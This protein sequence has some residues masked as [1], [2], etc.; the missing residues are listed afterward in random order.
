MLKKKKK[1]K[2]NSNVTFFNNVNRLRK[3]PSLKAKL[4]ISFILI[5]VIPSMIIASF[6]FSVSRNAMKDKVAEMT[7]E[8]SALIASSVDQSINET[9]KIALLPFSNQQL[10]NDFNNFDLN[11]FEILQKKRTAADYFLSIM[12][13]HP[14]VNHY[15]LVR[16]DGHVFGDPIQTVDTEEF[17][18][19]DFYQTVLE[20]N[21]EILWIG[22][23]EEDYENIYVFKSIKNDY[24]MDTGVLILTID[25]SYFDAV[26]DIPG[27]D[28]SIYLINEDNVTI[29]SNKEEHFGKPLTVHQNT[30]NNLVSVSESSN[31][32]QVVVTIPEAALRQDIDDVA[33]YVFLIVAVIAIIAIAVGLLI[34]FSI[35]KPINRICKLMKKV[36]NGD[37]NTR[38]SD[39]GNDE[40]GQLGRGFN[41]MVENITTI[42]EENKQVSSKALHSATKLKQISDDST[43]TAEQIAFAVEEMATGLLNQVDFAE[44]NQKEMEVLSYGINEVTTN[45][46]NVEISTQKTKQQSEESI[47]KMT[48]LTSVHTEVGMNMKQIDRVIIQLSQDVEGI[49][50]IIGMIQDITEQTNLLSLNASIEAARAGE[51]GRGFS[52]VAQEVRNLAE[53]SKHSTMKI[54]DIISNVFMQTKNSVDLVEKS[55]QL[56]E[57]QTESMQQTKSSFQEIIND[58]DNIICELKSIGSAIDLINQQKERVK[59]SV[60]EMVRFAENS[61]ATTEEITATTEEQYTAAEE[62]SIVSE[63]LVTTISN[64][65]SMINKFKINE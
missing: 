43:N 27:E 33:H 8:M 1:K 24:G 29:S 55:N 16:E 42:I 21:G 57:K 65:E 28:N 2:N 11:D 20:L 3:K 40:I 17:I 50:D 44:K 53:Q 18:D 25:R 47:R 32:W 4:I 19:S 10:F 12:F 5:T 41:H 26:F 45:V 52:V 6:V 37:L 61:S 30:K 23:Y 9:E 56:F 54:K 35:T 14:Q 15:F 46:K 62:L 60:N 49:Q 64:L 22:G 7:Y 48:N 31:G 51:A 39:T 34:T 58:T 13:S 36:E 59:D 63:N 38:S